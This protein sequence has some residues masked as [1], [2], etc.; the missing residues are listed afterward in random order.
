MFFGLAQVLLRSI[1]VEVDAARFA[2]NSTGADGVGLNT[3]EDYKVRLRAHKAKTQLWAADDASM[4]KLRA[5]VMA[6]V[7]AVPIMAHFRKGTGERE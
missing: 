4:S 7:Q 1:D 3:A 5:C 2:T 6:F